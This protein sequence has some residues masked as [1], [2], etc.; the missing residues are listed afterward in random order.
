MSQS[1]HTSQYDH[2]KSGFSEDDIKQ[3]ANYALDKSINALS[4]HI[5]TR[6]AEARYHALNSSQ[7][8]SK[9]TLPDLFSFRLIGPAFACILALAIFIG[10]EHDHP[11]D[12]HVF[13]DIQNLENMDAFLIYANTDE[14]ELDTIEELE[15]AY[16]LSEELANDQTIPTNKAFGV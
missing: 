3:G 15:F 1:N 11:S 10:I 7:Q 14:A 4:P 12:T 6:L 16:W 8:E 9:T 13:A 2:T 5:N